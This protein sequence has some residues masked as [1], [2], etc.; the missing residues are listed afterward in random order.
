[1]FDSLFKETIL[2][3]GVE[4][5]KALFRLSKAKIPLFEVKKCKKNQILFT[6]RKKDSEKVF[7]IYPK[8][9]YNISRRSVYS[10][11]NKGKTGLYKLWDFLCKRVGLFLGA[12]LFFTAVALSQNLVFGLELVGEQSYRA[13]TLT[14]LQQNGVSVYGAYKTGKENAV[15]ADLMKLDGVTFASVK[16]SGYRVRVELRVSS[17]SSAYPKKG[18]FKAEKS[19]KLLS[20][21]IIS[22]TPLKKEGEA[23]KAGEAIVGG[24]LVSSSGEKTEV[25]PIAKA[26]ILCTFQ[27]EIVANTEEDALAALRFYI[28]GTLK[29]VTAKRG[30]NGFLLTAEYEYTQSV[31]L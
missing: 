29:S 14:A 10:A 13:E 23:V 18:D 31:N 17:L 24:Y 20:L 3:E 8:M 1:M 6:V 2:L 5:E 26:T 12:A 25:Y 19:G 7:A 28:Q 16:K 4:P 30:E 11:Q 15:C 22:G 9:C 21:T 27:G